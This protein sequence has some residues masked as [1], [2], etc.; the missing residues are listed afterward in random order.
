[1]L[2]L[3]PILEMKPPSITTEK[4]ALRRALVPVL[5]SPAHFVLVPPSEP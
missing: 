1:M 4:P 5:K 3:P 2:G